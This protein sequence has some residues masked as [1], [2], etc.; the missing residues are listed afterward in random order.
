M[1]SLLI[2][3]PQTKRSIV[4]SFQSL[5]DAVPDALLIVNPEGGIELLN[6][7][8]EQMFEYRREELLGQPIELLMPERFRAKHFLHRMNYNA[9]PTTRPM[10]MRLDLL[11]RRRRGS[12]FPVEISLS[13]LPTVEGLFVISTI[14]DTSERKQA[15][16][17]L[18]KAEVR[19]RTLL[20]T[21]PAVTFMA[22]LDGGAN[23]MYVSPQIETML[24]FSQSEWLGDPVLWYRQLHPDD[25]ERWHKEFARTCAVGERFCSE[26]RFISR[27]GSVVWVHGEATLVRDD[28][29]TPSFLQGIAFDITE[30][31]VAEQMMLQSQSDLERRVQDRTADLARLNHE[32]ENEI[33]E[34]RK[35]EEQRTRYVAQ[36]EEASLRIEEQSRAVQAARERA[37]VANQTK[38]AFLA[39]MSHEIR[40]PMTA[41]LGYTDLLKET[42]TDEASRTAIETIGR[43]GNHLLSI[44]NDI[45]DLSKIEAGKMTIESIRFG[46]RQVLAD[47]E[48][49]MQ[50]RTQGKGIKLRIE[51]EG[52][53]PETILTDPTRL[54][55]ILVNL[56]GNAV[57]FTES[58]SVS[59]AVRLLA[60]EPAMLEWDVIDTGIGLTTEQQQALFQPFT[61]ADNSTVR[62]FGGTGLGLT[63][64]KRLAELLG[65][66]VRIVRSQVGVGTTFRLTIGIG[67]LEGIRLLQPSES[68][69]TQ[70]EPERDLATVLHLPD[71]CRILLAEDGPDNQ[72]L[73]SFVLKKAGAVVTVAENGQQAVDLVEAAGDKPYDVILMDMQMPI[74]D[75]Y[76]AT[77]L[78]RRQGYTRPIV[79]LTAHAMSGDR[80]KCLNSGCNDYATKPIDRLCLIQQVARQIPAAMS[81]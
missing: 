47:V 78:L 1:E 55:Q 73:I 65:G 7:Q 36:L 77:T 17:K 54:R 58:G 67:P 57:K 39:N 61:Q 75:G 38:S 66:D 19:Y 3:L 64:S 5:A 52:L 62:K 49:L 45:L 37:E 25:R 43:N 26:Y 28:D 81:R 53:L 20:E 79:A 15:E 76:T 14:R 30:R 56:V 29:G 68:L 70:E 31:K 32:L 69:A 42:L 80:E 8:T 46:L 51:Q 9:A 40:T 11:G 12:E 50:V 74:M 72:R 16:T 60:Q 21:I 4:E 48:S 63:I 35:A 71:G 59:L 10:G 34:R 13:P 23:E 6:S 33:I 2:D 27:G 44:I 41:I 18:R 24:G 22:S